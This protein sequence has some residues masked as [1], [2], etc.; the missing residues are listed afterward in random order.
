MT[1]KELVQTVAEKLKINYDSAENAVL[2]TMAAITVGLANTG[3][4]TI[5][6]FGTFSVRERPPR[7]ARNPKTGEQIEV[8]A[9]K[10]VAFKAGKGTLNAIL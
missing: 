10:I 6:N 4:V 7:T 5:P 9:K 1:K 8:P 2:V 3:S